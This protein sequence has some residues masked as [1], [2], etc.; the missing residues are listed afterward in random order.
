MAGFLLSNKQFYKGNYHQFSLSK[1][2]ASTSA[3]ISHISLFN[4]LLTPSIVAENLEDNK[5]IVYH[6]TKAVQSLLFIFPPKLQIL[7]S[8]LFYNE[9]LTIKN[10]YESLSNYSFT[11]NIS[12][13]LDIIFINQGLTNLPIGTSFIQLLNESINCTLPSS[14]LEDKLNF[15]LCL[16]N[17]QQLY[18][19]DD[20]TIRDKIDRITNICNYTNTM[21]S[22]FKDIAISNDRLQSAV[23]I[24]KLLGYSNSA[25]Q[26]IAGIIEKW[27]LQNLSI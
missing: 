20:L 2:L 18:S 19:I 24:G 13:P 8:I 3:T 7:F 25:I 14:Y 22:S 23:I 21:L 26:D 5:T 27:Q 10:N 4:Y 1:A 12:T 9:E 15:L 6:D 17:K 16:N 11:Y